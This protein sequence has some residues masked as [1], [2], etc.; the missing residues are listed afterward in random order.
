MSHYGTLRDYRFEGKDADDIR[1]SDLYGRDDEKL[2][3]IVD[4]IFD[5]GSGYI[6]YIV[7]DTGGWLSSK[8]FIV[9]AERLQPSAEHEDDYQ[10]NLSKDQVKSFPAYDE[11]AVK[12]RDRWGD[13]EKRYD[14]LW[15][16]TGDVLHREDAPDRIITP[17]PSE[18]PTAT[19]SSSGSTTIGSSSVTEPPRPI[20]STFK[21]VRDPVKGRPSTVT[22]TTAY[23]TTGSGQPDVVNRQSPYGSHLGDRWNRFEDRLREDRSR[24]THGCGVC[25]TGP[26]SVRDTDRERKVG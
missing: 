23:R 10:V 26:S 17:S 1:G 9:P 13:Y 7:V 4:I 14:A 12:D 19:S 25:G 5:H 20:S 15:T 6:R 2:G 16:T 21:E 8:K 24:I 18:M 11:D 3:E 22:D